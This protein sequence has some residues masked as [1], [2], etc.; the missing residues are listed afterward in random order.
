MTSPTASARGLLANAA[1]LYAM[2]PDLQDELEQ[3]A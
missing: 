3:L 2:R 1:D